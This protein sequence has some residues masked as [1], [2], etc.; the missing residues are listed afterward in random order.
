MEDMGFRGAGSGGQMGDYVVIDW[1]IQVVWDARDGRQHM[2]L[3]T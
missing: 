1:G 3:V 2:I